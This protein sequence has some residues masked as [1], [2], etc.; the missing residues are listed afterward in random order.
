MKTR[1]NQS[2]IAH[3]A[4]VMIVVVVGVVSV[5]GWLVI[6]RADDAEVQNTI[7]RDRVYEIAQVSKEIIHNN[8]KAEELDKLEESEIT[9]HIS[10]QSTGSNSGNEWC[11]LKI[12]ARTIKIKSDDDPIV[13]K[14]KNTYKEFVQDSWVQSYSNPSSMNESNIPLKF[15]ADLNLRE[16]QDEEN[17]PIVCNIEI[18]SSNLVFHAGLVNEQDQLYYSLLVDCSWRSTVRGL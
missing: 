11:G 14:I 1:V 2:G 10:E 9:C 4:I 13:S 17:R 16:Y 8:F 6:K 18:G 15:K 5:A 7:R 12:E 3:I